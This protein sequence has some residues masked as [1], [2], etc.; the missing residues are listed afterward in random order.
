MLLRTINDTFFQIV[1]KVKNTYGPTQQNEL[2]PVIF[3]KYLAKKFFYVYTSHI[4]CNAAINQLKGN[5]MFDFYKEW[6]KKWQETAK[7]IKQVNEFWIESIISS[8]K[9]LQK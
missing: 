1:Q 6:D 4:C 7:Q 9:Q 3:F 2:P 8:L 5:A